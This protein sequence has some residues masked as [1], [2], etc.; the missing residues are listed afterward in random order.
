M[1]NGSQ[2]IMDFNGEGAFNGKTLFFE[3]NS[4]DGESNLTFFGSK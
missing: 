2:Q 4:L 3:L 1:A